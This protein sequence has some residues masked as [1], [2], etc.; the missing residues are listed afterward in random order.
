[1]NRSGAA[2]ERLSVLIVEDNPA[3]AALVDEMLRAANLVA[4]GAITPEIHHVETLRD[5]LVAVR[6]PFDVALLDLGLPDASG[7]DGLNALSAAVPEL[8]AVVLTGVRDPELA[9]RAL[10]AGA[11]DFLVKGEVQGD[12]L[13][14]CL[15]SAVARHAKRQPRVLGRQGVNGGGEKTAMDGHPPGGPTPAAGPAAAQAGPRRDRAEISPRR[16]LLV[17]DNPGDAELVQIALSEGSTAFAV[18]RVERVGEALAYLS[19]RDV[20]A[21]LLDLGLPDAAGLDGVERIRAAFPELPVVILTG[22]YDVGVEAVRSGVQDY[23]RKDALAPQDLQRAIAYAIER[24]GHAQRAREL[25]RERAAHAATQAAAKLLEDVNE[26]LAMATREARE[27]LE[28]EAAARA[29]AAHRSVELEALFAAM[30]DPVLVFGEDG[31][32]ESTNPAAAKF[33]G[34]D[35]RG[36]LPAG[37]IEAAG[38]RSSDGAKVVAESLAASRALEGEIVVGEKLRVRASG[39]ER[40]AL[41]SA[42]PLWRGDSVRG[43]MCV[44]RDVTE[45]DRAEHALRENDERKNHFLAMLSH[46]LRNPLAPI[47]NCLYILERAAPG[48]EQS[49]RAR[50]VIDRQVHHLT[51]LVDDLLD[52]TRISRGKIAL[53]RQRIDVCALARQVAD[54]HRSVFAGNGIEFD[55]TVI[56]PP[57]HVNGDPTR[58]AQVI[59]NLLD[60]AAKFTPRGGRAALS[61]ARAG[62]DLCTIRVHDTGK[63]IAPAALEHMFEPFMQADSTLDRTLGGLGL[64]LALVKGL[65]E[66]HDGG[67]TAHSAGL[68]R[69]AE[70]VVTLPLDRAYESRLDE[71]VVPGSTVPVRR[72]LVIEDNADAAESLKEVL[73]LSGH[74]VE[75]ASSGPEGL[76]KA[77]AFHPE[78]VL[79]DIGLPAMDGFEVAR[80]M[81]ADPVLRSMALVAVSGYAAPADLERATDA[82]F[83]RHLTK[84]VDRDELERVIGEVG[85]PQMRRARAEAEP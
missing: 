2:S 20:D 28:R 65:A 79:C 27:A 16:V 70:F 49:R 3:D 85:D 6:Q 60:N 10:L 12:L 78:I 15:R 69:G 52:V 71:R 35:V 57:L 64:G 38:I 44:Y 18:E 31:R 66:L 8:P 25:A 63:G 74:T 36:F 33:F 41:V 45:L 19:S 62:E 24:N 21:V 32:I 13:L 56:E 42:S 51:R 29:L 30:T 34:T 11:E 50:T 5:A 58:I 22:S 1:V 68:G 72:I 53:H 40:V 83:E 67:A 76:E 59:G 46:E 14:R 81:R 26:R 37:F 23:V 77:R 75:I 61:V 43:A 39:G 55:T 7:V 4:R 82:G 9:A 73:E 80:A 17:E 48:G 84:P 47:R 54:D